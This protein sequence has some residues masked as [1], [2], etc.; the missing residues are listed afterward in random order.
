M[1]MA[2]KV[3]VVAFLLAVP[4]AQS[5]AWII[6]QVEPDASLASAEVVPFDHQPTIDRFEIDKYYLP[7]F[8][9]DEDAL[10]L[11][12]TRGAGDAGVTKI[13]IVH[14]VIMNLTGFAW[15]DY[16]VRLLSDPVGEFPGDDDTVQLI[17]ANAVQAVRQTGGDIRL[18]GLPVTAT[19]NQIDWRSTDASQNVPTGTFD[20]QPT[21]QLVLRT[22]DIDVSKLEAGDWFELK[23]W[24]TVPEPA[25]LT[26]LGLGLA[27]MLGRRARRAG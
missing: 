12:F 22:I 7:G 16:H 18:G 26:L 2:S 5:Q 24:P 23:Q 14:E 13:R 8:I 6:T 10:I 4:V 20:D 25:T 17:G 1:R 19:L 3:A 9:P 11:K 15:D 21:N 27:A